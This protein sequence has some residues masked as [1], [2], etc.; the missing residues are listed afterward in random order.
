MAADIERHRARRAAGLAIVKQYLDWADGAE[1]MCEA[2][3]LTAER[4]LAH[5]DAELRALARGYPFERL[6]E[7]EEGP[8]P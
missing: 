8:L 6:P 3:Q 5:D 4:L 1:A 2:A 7:Y